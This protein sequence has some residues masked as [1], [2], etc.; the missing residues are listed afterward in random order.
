MH[1][2]KFASSYRALYQNYTMQKEAKI[3]LTLLLTC[4]SMCIFSDRIMIT[5][6]AVC[7]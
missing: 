5:T 6:P 4:E 7:V 1:L 3:G 2:A